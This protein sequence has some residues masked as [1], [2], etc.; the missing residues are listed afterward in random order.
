MIIARAK[1]GSGKTAICNITIDIPTKYIS[2]NKSEY[3]L[4]G[5]GESTTLNATVSPSS[6]SQEVNWTSSN[7]SVATVDNVGKVTSVGVGTCEITATSNEDNSLKASCNITV[8]EVRVTS[9]TLNKT[10]YTFTNITP[11]Q[12]TATILPENAVNKEVEW[13]SNNTSV[14][15]VDNNG[16][17]TPKN[18]G[19]CKITVKSKDGS[20]KTATCDI[21]VNI[22][23]LVTSITLNKTSYT[24]TNTTPLQLNATVKPDNATNKEITWESTNPSILVVDQTGKVMV[25]SNK[26]SGMIIARAKDGSG[27]SAVCNITV[28]I[29]GSTYKKGDINKDG[30]VTV[31]DV[32]YGLKAL[33]KGTITAE[34]I[35]IGDVN[36]DGKFSVMDA[37]K[38][39]RFIVGKISSLD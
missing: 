36:G 19:T 32:R 5:I 24:F 18:N 15:T 29:G 1:D 22:S 28:N 6:M 34:E 14:A 31:M 35:K 7:T 21:T 12:L 10:S 38:I 26:G 27:K 16:K 37:R 33:T 30:K 3:T 2:L 11:L 20:E 23:I 13:T 25:T 8:Q 9:I 39:L 17:V 4:N